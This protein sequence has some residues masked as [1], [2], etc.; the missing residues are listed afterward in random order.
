MKKKE[1]L[2][3]SIILLGAC[4]VRLY[5]FDNPIADWHSWRQAD[6]SAVSRN[7]VKNGF[8]IL[9]PHFDDLSNVAS[10]KDNPHGYRF[11]EFPLYNLAQAGMFVFFGIFTIEEWGRIVTI[12]SSLLTIIFL[13]KIVSKYSTK[14]AGLLTAFFYAF[15]PFNIYYGRVILPDPSMIMAI[16]GGFYFFDR[17]IEKTQK[18]IKLNQDFFLSL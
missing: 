7:F 5:R 14:N 16:L 6:T 12:I 15:L 3:L 17:W 9:H 4:I 11:V 2:M 13:Y 8:D 18:E 1:L 10:G